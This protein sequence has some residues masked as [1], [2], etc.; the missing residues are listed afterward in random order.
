MPEQPPQPEAATAFGGAMFATGY[1]FTFIK[2][3]ELLCGIML[4]SGFKS[5]LAAVIILPVTINIFLFHAILNPASMVISV[6]LLVLNLFLG[7]CY[8]K[9]YEGMLS[10][11]NAWKY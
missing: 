11:G 4:L 7:Y 1:M 10:A 5:Q 6:V 9:N 2:V 3:T 8:R